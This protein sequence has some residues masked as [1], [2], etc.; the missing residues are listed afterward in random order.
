MINYFKN[1]CLPDNRSMSA[2]SDLV[3]CTLKLHFP[4]FLVGRKISCW[5]WM[6]RS[7]DILVLLPGQAGDPNLTACCQLVAELQRLSLGFYELAG[8]G[9]QPPH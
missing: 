4:Q 9:V 1:P 7:W 5:S 6:F 2:T 3:A 8:T